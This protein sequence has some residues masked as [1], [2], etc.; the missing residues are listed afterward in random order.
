MYSK[1]AAERSLWDRERIGTTPQ[2]SMS[3]A[4]RRDPVWDTGRDRI[5]LS[6]A[7]IDG[8][9]DVTVR[10]TLR[11][12]PGKTD[13]DGHRHLEKTFLVDH[14]PGALSAG[15]YLAR[16]LHLDPLHPGKEARHVPLF[17]DPRTNA[18]ITYEAAKRELMLRLRLAGYPDLAS[19]LHSLRGG[20]GTA[21][22]DTAGSFIAG[23]AGHWVSNAKY[24]YFF[25]L[26]NS[27]ELG[28]L[29]MA[30][31]DAG[32]LADPSGPALKRPRRA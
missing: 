17:R 23:A 3:P 15:L 21:L 18:E 7:E 2:K 25:Q 12:P 31:D 32:S 30:R 20:A 24:S 1:Q 13:P 27:T 5:T 16:M 9:P 6:A 28:A 19:G 26:R 22:N 4:T 29:R 10:I 14:T 8:C 11:L